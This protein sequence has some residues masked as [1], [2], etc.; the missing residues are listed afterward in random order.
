MWV[1]RNMKQKTISQEFTLS[2]RG[3]HTGNAINLRF[4]PA[5]INQGIVFK[6]I[7]LPDAPLIKA[8]PENVRV[9][10]EVPR[11]TSL[12]D[13]ENH[14]H[15]VEHVMSAFCGLGLTNVLIEID[16]TELPG[17]DGSALDYFTALKEAGI[18]EQDGEV[19][20]Y[21]IVEPIGVELKGC[22]IFIVP[23]KE[24]KISYTLDY[25]DS[26]IRSQHATLTV[27]E[28]VYQKEI[29]PCRTF[30]MESEAKELQAQG[31]G[32]GA[33]H[34]N[35]LVIGK[36][37]V[38]DN[39]LRFP[40][41]CARHKI[42]DFIGDLY[43]LG[44]PL[45][46]HVYA[47]KSGHT[48][49]FFLL[50][51]ILKQKMWMDRRS[52]VAPF[53]VREGEQMDIHQIMKILPHRHPFLLIDK[54]VEIS[55]PKRVVSIKNVTAN[56]PFFQGH[57]PTRPI[58]PGV[59]MIEAMAQTAGIAFLTNEAHRGKVAFFMA[60]DQVKFRKPVSPG[61]QLVIEAEVLKDK[62]RIGKAKAL[63]RVNGGIV[64]EAVMMFSF[65]DESI[66]YE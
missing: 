14:I 15:T 33:N 34:K 58:M 48:L 38:V 16:G 24:L 37:G 56:E 27:T 55:A 63:A 32:K 51:K 29:A 44:A 12:S 35:T 45:R 26:F 3:L 54:V 49:N 2:G 42:L 60:A 57:F 20:P 36:E 5:E 13:G 8:L 28:D 30:C 52:T 6:R 19:V 23:S 4:K 18:E 53:K 17:L 50:K 59:L 43:L 9:D 61:D 39:E 64:A 10:T 25:P 1:I 31:L 66:L 62:V 22:S 47:T 46:G 40:D 21:E 65:T 11:C 41:E 7:D